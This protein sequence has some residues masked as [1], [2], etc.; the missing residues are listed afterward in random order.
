MSFMSVPYIL[1][2]CS[3]VDKFWCHEARSFLRDK[4]TCTLCTALI[5]SQEDSKV[6]ENLL[7]SKV[8]SFSKIS[9]YCPQESGSLE[10]QILQL[11]EKMKLMSCTFMKMNWK[12][13][14]I[15]VC[16][17]I[18]LSRRYSRRKERSKKYPYVSRLPV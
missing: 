8:I 6:V 14:V 3:L 10:Q 5:R 2:N 9:V 16:Q 18:L 4:R 12:W 1:H 11:I 7:N 15:A 13:D 17:E